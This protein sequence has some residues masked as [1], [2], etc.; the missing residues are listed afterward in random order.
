VDRC[1]EW[2]SAEDAPFAEA[3]KRQGRGTR[4]EFEARWADVRV[5]VCRAPEPPVARIV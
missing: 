4:A 2:D 5:Q 3:F 1:Y